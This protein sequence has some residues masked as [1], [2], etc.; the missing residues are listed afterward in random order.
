MSVEIRHLR[1]VRA[2]AET[3]SLTRAGT[4]LHLTQSALSHQLRD[5]E[6]RLET[7]LFLRVGKRLKLTPA[8]EQLL[9]SAHEVLATIER[10]EGAIRRLGGSQRGLLRLTT[11]CYTCYHWLPATL[12]RYHRAHPHVDVRIDVRATNAPVAALLEGRIELALV[13]DTVRD[14]R[15]VVRPLFDDELVAVVAPSHRLAK[16]PYV[17]VGGDFALETLLTYSP[18]E[19]S[20]VFQRVLNPA[21]VAPARHLVVPLTE[22]MIELAK[23]GLG[24]G[25]LSRWAVAPHVRA[26][27]LSA[28]RVTKAGFSRRWSAAVLKN[29]IRDAHVCAFIELLASQPPF[30]MPAAVSRGRSLRTGARTR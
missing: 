8:G 5:I 2:V 14:R 27:S 21:R 10:T 7:P 29:S 28:L 11:E 19:N 24:V 1:L 22:A 4:E 15:I 20:T 16:K 26:G 9:A 6:S 13:S 25:V 17:D 3:G 18:K 23:A 30:S 12:K